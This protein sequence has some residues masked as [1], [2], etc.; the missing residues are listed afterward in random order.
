MM[1]YKQ[2]KNSKLSKT[3]NS[4]NAETGDNSSADSEFSMRGA[5]NKTTGNINNVPKNI[6]L[7]SDNLTWR[8]P[9]EIIAALIFSGGLGYG[10]DIFFGSQPIALIICLIFGVIAGLYNIYKIYA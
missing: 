10:I 1:V 2:V 4:L 7:Y 3:E 5:E 8:I 6:M 9:L